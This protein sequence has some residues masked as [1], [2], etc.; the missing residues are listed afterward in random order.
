MSRRYT[1][2]SLQR[3]SVSSTV[4]V[5]EKLKAVTPSATFCVGW[6]TSSCHQLPSVLHNY[7][8]KQGR[9]AWPVPNE[10]E[11]EEEKQISRTP[12]NPLPR[13]VGAGERCFHPPSVSIALA[14]AAAGHGSRS[15]HVKSADALPVT[16]CLL[17][18]IIGK[19]GWPGL[20]TK[21]RFLISY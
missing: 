12:P 14:W 4:E 3:N 6:C 13:H 11:E 19:L 8:P 21:N 2:I 1:C 9:P 20:E 10:E 18:P 15:A 5:I 7:I 16:I 17:A